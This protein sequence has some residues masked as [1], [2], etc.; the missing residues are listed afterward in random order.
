[1]KYLIILLIISSIFAD[2]FKGIKVINIDR[3][4]DTASHIVEFTN[5]YK[6]ETTTP[7]KEFVFG[8]TKEQSDFLAIITATDEDNKE[9]DVKKLNTK[10]EY[11]YIL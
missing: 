2:E 8:L 5:S 1:M 3:R 11:K 10:T 7:Q 4:I 6:F 9:L